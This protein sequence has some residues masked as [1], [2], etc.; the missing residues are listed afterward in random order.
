MDRVQCAIEDINVAV[1][2]VMKEATLEIMADL[3]REEKY[4]GSP[5]LI[6]FQGFL[7]SLCLK[8]EEQT[9][10]DKYYAQIY[11]ERGRQALERVSYRTGT[12]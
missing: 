3:L 8:P 6:V 12:L 7:R 4:R 5:T 10:E 2:Q 11:R 9:Q 1:R